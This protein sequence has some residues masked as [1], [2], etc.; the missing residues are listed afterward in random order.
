MKIIEPTTKRL[1]LRQWGKY[2]LHEFSSI[3]SDPAVMKFYPK[4][5]TKKESDAFANKIQSIIENKGWGFW[6]VELKYE[7]K[8]IAFV[9]LHEPNDILPCTPCIEL[10]WRLAK[11]Y[12]GKGYATEAANAALKIAFEVLNVEAVYSYSSIL[13]K[14]SQAVMTRLN[15]FNTHQNFSH[16]SIPTGN[17]LREHVL[18]KITQQHWKSL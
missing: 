5:L 10:G 6:A 3:N 12:W 11:E 7:K 8:F 15:M 4:T 13:N 16:P 1:Q 17:P 9:G 18:F 2:D 14:K